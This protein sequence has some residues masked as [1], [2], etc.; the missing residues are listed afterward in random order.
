MK[1]LRDTDIGRYLAAI[2]RTIH[3]VRAIFSVCATIL[4]AIPFLAGFA[5]N[6]SAPLL[7]HLL[8]P[9][10]FLVAH[11][12][13]F[14]LPFVQRKIRWL[15]FWLTVTFVAALGAG[16]LYWG[17]REAA[18]STFTPQG[19]FAIPRWVNPNIDVPFPTVAVYFLVPSAAGAALYCLVL[20][21]FLRI[22]RK[23]RAEEHQRRASRGDRSE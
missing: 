19:L 23:Y 2:A 15:L 1:S 7:L 11:F 9:A 22:Y 4:F 14:R 17:Y 6:R 3:P 8:Y 20:G 18:A 10:L 13:W 5:V 16:F 21:L 12:V